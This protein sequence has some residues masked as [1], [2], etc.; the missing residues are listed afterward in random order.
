MSSHNQTLEWILVQDGLRQAIPRVEGEAAE[1]PSSYAALQ[2]RALCDNLI[3]LQ[4]C[5][6]SYLVYGS[7]AMFECYVRPSP[8]PFFFDLKGSQK[9]TSNRP[10]T[11]S[12]RSTVGGAS[13]GMDPAVRAL[14]IVTLLVRMLRKKRLEAS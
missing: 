1:A 9:A 4:V 14:R 2:A 5:T 10:P 11:M 6:H 3:L 13:L 8:S 7:S 12:P